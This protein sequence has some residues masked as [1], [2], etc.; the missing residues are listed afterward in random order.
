MTVL[1]IEGC[2]TNRM[3]KSFKMIWIAL[4]R[5]G[6]ILGGMKFNKVMRISRKR[7]PGNPSYVML[8]E[9]LEE[10][11]STQYLAGCVYSKQLEVGYPNSSC[12]W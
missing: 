4:I 11:T 3:S 6:Q 12:R 9:T 8:G 10:V 1:F 7:T 5:F 2:K